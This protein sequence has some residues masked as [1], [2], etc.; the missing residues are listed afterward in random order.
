M[1]KILSVLF[2]CFIILGY[3]VMPLAI[4]KNDNSDKNQNRITASA[5]NDFENLADELD[6][7]A[8]D[9]SED[10]EDEEN[11]SD[12]DDLEEE[13]DNSG[14]GNR[15]EKRTESR[16]IDSEGNEVRIKEKIKFRD[17]EYEIETEVEIEGEGDN[18]NAV[19]SRGERHKIRVTPERIKA[20]IRERFK[21]A[22]VSDVRLEEVERNNIPAVVYK[23]N[24]E[25]PGK[26]LGIFKMV[27]K[28]ETDVD[29]ETGEI[30]DVN[31]PWW[32]VLVSGLIDE[33]E[34]GNETD[35]SGVENETP[36]PGEEV[37]ETEVVEEE[38]VSG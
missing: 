21:N 18:I 26:F 30:V 14:R 2:L 33:V 34:E 6:D 31:V 1:K 10:L 19:D 8:S 25:H 12:E 22:N 9:D 29:P 35:G 11:E 15:E 27:V 13:S 3:A 28:A 4:A 36:V 23:V 20:T 37:N 7:N 24:S 38:N 5:A 32:A 17:G 16:F